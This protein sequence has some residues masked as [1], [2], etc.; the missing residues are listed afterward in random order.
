MPTIFGD[1]DGDLTGHSEGENQVLQLDN[2][3]GGTAYGDATGALRGHARGG[4]DIL[5]GGNNADVNL[6]FGDASGLAETEE[7]AFGIPFRLL[8][9]ESGPCAREFQSRFPQ[10]VITGFRT[11]SRAGTHPRSMSGAPG[12]YF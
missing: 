5:T 7:S 3:D 8:P 2:E 12:S 4:D 1:I 10:P 6:L 11:S 9:C